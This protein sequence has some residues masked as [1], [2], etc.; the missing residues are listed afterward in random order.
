MVSKMSLLQIHLADHQETEPR[1]CGTVYENRLCVSSDPGVNAG[2][3]LCRWVQHQ[4]VPDH[5]EVVGFLY[6]L[7]ACRV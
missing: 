1:D 2:Q 7:P 5:C 3:S 4:K 6:D